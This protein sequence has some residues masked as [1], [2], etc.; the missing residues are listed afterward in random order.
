MCGPTAIHALMR[1][2]PAHVQPTSLSFATSTNQ[3]RCKSYFCPSGLA[4]QSTA[5]R[6]LS[7]WLGSLVGGKGCQQAAARRSRLWEVKSELAKL[8]VGFDA[9]ER[10]SASFAGWQPWWHVRGGPL[11]LRFPLQLG[12]CRGTAHGKPDIRIGLG[13][14]R[15]DMCVPCRTKKSRFHRREQ[16]AREWRWAG[17]LP[18]APSQG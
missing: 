8:R 16:R 13:K 17:R 14:A 2:S 9:R 18:P 11:S 5:R 4:P 3:Q 1:L 10:V 15:A 7:R 12:H 6:E